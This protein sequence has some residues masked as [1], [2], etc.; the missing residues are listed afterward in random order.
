MCVRTGTAVA[1]QTDEIL[2]LPSANCTLSGL[3]LLN[4]RR[5]VWENIRSKERLEKH[6]DHDRV[7]FIDY[8]GFYVEHVVH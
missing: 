2:R 3:T 6:S 4:Y 5:V 7:D 1:T 8:Y